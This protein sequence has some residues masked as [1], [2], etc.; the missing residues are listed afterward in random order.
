MQLD[1]RF[2]TF[3]P[4]SPKALMS[5]YFR[6]HQGD[7]ETRRP[8]RSVIGFYSVIVSSEKEINRKL[9]DGDNQGYLSA[10]WR[11]APFACQSILITI[12][13]TPAVR[14]RPCWVV[15]RCS[16]TP[17]WFCNQR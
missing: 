12:P 15:V 13:S 7:L 5:P 17:F 10:E 4:N 14:P 8:I 1:G 2:P 16:T 11:Q 6:K 9:A 3:K